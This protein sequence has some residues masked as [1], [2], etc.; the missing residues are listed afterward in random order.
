MLTH[1]GAMKYCHPR[2]RLEEESANTYWGFFFLKCFDRFQTKGYRIRWAIRSV[3]YRQ[4]WI[5][6]QVNCG[7]IQHPSW[8]SWSGVLVSIKFSLTWVY[9]YSKYASL[10]RMPVHGK[11][12]KLL[13]SSTMLWIWNLFSHHINFFTSSDKQLRTTSS[14]L[15]RILSKLFYVLDLMTEARHGQI[16]HNNNMDTHI[17]SGVWFTLPMA[18]S[19]D[20]TLT[21]SKCSA[22][23]RWLPH[24]RR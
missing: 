9:A 22:N 11:R 14:I 3:S 23:R 8:G 6:S 21:Y 16:E 4:T 24:F 2:M 1:S 19:I 12:F 7:C 18:S 5:S 20:S 10:P 15:T 13:R 17:F